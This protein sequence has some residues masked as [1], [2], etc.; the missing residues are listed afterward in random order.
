MLEENFKQIINIIK[1]DIKATGLK[2]AIQVN[3][4]LIELYFRLGK[5]LYDNYEYGNKFID[6]VASELKLE[7]PN[8]TG[9]SVRNLKYMKKFYAE[10]KDDELVQH[11]VAQVP[12]GHN[13]VLMDKVKD[14]EIRKIYLQGIIENGWGRSMLVHQIE[15]NYHLRIGTSDNNFVI[16]LPKD[17]SDLANHII[18]DPYIFDFI[19]LKNDY[20]EQELENELLIKIKNLLVELGKGF[21]F[22][23]S[24]YKISMEDRDYYIDLLFYHLELRCYIVVELKATSFKPEY[25]GQL[26]FYVTAIDETLKKE[27]D[28]PTLGL[29][30][31]KEKNK[32]SVEWSLKGT[33]LPIG[34]SS[35]KLKEY[36]PRDILD[37][38]PTEE[39]IN[40]HIDIESGDK[41][42]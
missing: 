31:C 9:Y 22:V 23:G 4:N 12:W 26:G 32:L 34:V 40:L 13:V 10:Y 39:E 37:K 3:H 8:A 17:N 25:I 41:N 2:T 19:S 6:E 18:K 33:S 42:E 15:L 24:Q 16:T 21:S 27:I 14:K 5:I 35:Y 36:I 11:L 28:N 7:Y 38:L 30:L 1:S 29:L 20:K